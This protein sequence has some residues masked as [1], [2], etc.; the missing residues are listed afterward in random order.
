MRKPEI[1][2][3][4]RREGI[5]CRFGVETPRLHPPIPVPIMTSHFRPSPR[6]DLG[7]VDTHGRG[8]KGTPT[9]DLL[10]PN[11]QYSF[12]KDGDVYDPSISE[13]G[14]MDSVPKLWY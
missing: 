11:R 14:R 6:K 13:Q 12:L 10:V 2:S 5:G 7:Q 4:P 9:S 8:N 3:S 1:L